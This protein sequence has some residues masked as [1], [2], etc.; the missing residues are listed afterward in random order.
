MLV[1]RA[2]PPSDPTRDDAIRKYSSLGARDKICKQKSLNP[3]QNRM[4]LIFGKLT[5]VSEADEVIVDT[6][7]RLLPRTDTAKDSA[8]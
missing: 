5:I 6:L 7:M 8:H 4:K 2:M 3:L 1:A